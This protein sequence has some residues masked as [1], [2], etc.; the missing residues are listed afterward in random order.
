MSTS[1]KNVPHE[2]HVLV[3]EDDGAVANSL[4]R[5]LE[6]LGRTVHVRPSSAEAL[7]CLEETPDICVVVTDIRLPEGS[8][9]QLAESVLGNRPEALAAEIII[10]TGHATTETVTAAMNLGACDFL[11]KPF[12]LEQVDAAI[13]RAATRAAARRAAA[14]L[15]ARPHAAPPGLLPA[16]PGQSEAAFDLP[17]E[18]DRVPAGAEAARAPFDLVPLVEGVVRRAIAGTDMA[19]E[20]AP[21]RPLLVVAAREGLARAMAL[22]LDTAIEWAPAGSRFRW[23]LEAVRGSQRADARVAILI[24]P[25]RSGATPPLDGAAPPA[26]AGGAGGSLESLRPLLARHLAVQSGASLS[27]WERPQGMAGIRLTLPPAPGA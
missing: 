4:R 6:A 18:L 22:C 1:M 15:I 17:E 13:T 12:R 20:T 5:G 26:P 9:L 21:P 10:I 27:S 14:A 7:R 16:G 8:G 3:V 24:A 19:I 25:G 11:H 23:R 2:A